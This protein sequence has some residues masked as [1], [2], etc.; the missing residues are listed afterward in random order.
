MPR[1]RRVRREQPASWRACKSTRSR[2][3]GGGGDHDDHDDD[4]DIAID[5]YIDD[6]K[7]AEEEE[8][9]AAAMRV[10][11]R[12]ASWAASAPSAKGARGAPRAPRAPSLSV[13]EVFAS[14]QGEGPHTGRPS[15]FLRLGLCNL[16]CA[17]CDTKYTWLFS[18]EQ[19]DAVK[20]R[21]PHAERHGARLDLDTTYDKATELTRMSTEEVE[22]R[23]LRASRRSHS[24]VVVAAAAAGGTSGSGGHH[25]HQDDHDDDKGNGGVRA[26]V[27]TGGEP[28]L[29][30]KP[31]LELVPRLTERHRYAVEFET[32]GTLLPAG[33]E[34]YPGV[35][36]N[37]SPKLS[38]SRQ[39]ERKRV[40]RDVLD[41]FARAL[42]HTSAFKFVV[43]GERDL[44][45]VRELLASLT[46]PVD[47]SR[48]W[49]MPQGTLPEELATA[50][51]ERVVDWCVTHGYQYSHRVHVAI[52]GDKRGV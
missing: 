32:N 17:W 21:V 45:E 14:I 24:S 12:A 19:R 40:R 34:R 6:E 36:F 27:V 35:H 51:R 44:Q 50:A 3:V 42:P 30:A 26:V 37:V 16:E 23:I 1:A 43:D 33:L 46:V 29:H 4:I 25:H 20:Q 52:W 28:L 31:L 15:V 13:S 22:A 10:W 9:R 39:S 2:P 48:V 18:D 49:L 8:L 5:G 41:Y 7:E 38:N 11:R 47:P